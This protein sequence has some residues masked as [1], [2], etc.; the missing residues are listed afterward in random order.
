VHNVA[1]HDITFLDCRSP[2][3]GTFH[4]MGIGQAPLAYWIAVDAAPQFQVAGVNQSGRTR[5][6]VIRSIF[7]EG[8]SFALFVYPFSG[9]RCR[10][11][12]VE[13]GKFQVSSIG[14]AGVYV[15]NCDSVRMVQTWSGYV[16]TL[17]DVCNL[18][19][20]RHA[21]LEGCFAEGA[22][23]SAT[24]I[25]AASDVTCLEVIECFNYSTLAPSGTSQAVRTFEQKDGVLKR[26]DNGG[27]FTTMPGY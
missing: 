26:S 21:R 8:P 9:N 17:Q 5:V 25:K 4:G 19:N 14:G 1:A 11:V 6:S 15:N 12:Y 22:H 23:T 20:V 16:G 27:A 18:V 10:S 7:D 2:D 24:R 3:L 13:G